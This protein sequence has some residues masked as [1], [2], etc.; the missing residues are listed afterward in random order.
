MYVC[1]HNTRQ[2]QFLIQL[3]D[4]LL[5][6]GKFLLK[7]LRLSPQMYRRTCNLGGR[8]RKGDRGLKHWWSKPSSTMEMSLNASEDTW[9]GSNVNRFLL[10]A[11]YKKTTV[12]REMVNFAPFSS[13]TIHSRAGFLKFF[14]KTAWASL[15][16]NSCIK[17]SPYFAR[18]S[19]RAVNPANQWGTERSSRIL[20]IL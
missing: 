14:A 18:V 4:F 6:E 5:L 16:T 12:K 20:H 11:S 13:E 9:S 2:L 10:M 8:L 1:I 17:G 3:F 19:T 15:T 7:H